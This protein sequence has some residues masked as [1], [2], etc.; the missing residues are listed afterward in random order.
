MKYFI[1]LVGLLIMGCTNSIVGSGGQVADRD[2]IIVTYHYDYCWDS[3]GY[4]KEMIYL[5]RLDNILNNI[6]LDVR[7][8]RNHIPS[9]E[10]CESK[11]QVVLRTQN[12]DKTI[13]VMKL[14]YERVLPDV[15]IFIDTCEY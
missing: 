11:Y 4:T 5:K 6:I 1:G 7:P 13:I 12:L 14:W 9:T 3:L 2:V 15:Q 10:G 8:I